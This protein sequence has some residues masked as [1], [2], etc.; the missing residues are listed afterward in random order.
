MGILFIKKT[1]KYTSEEDIATKSEKLGARGP[2][3]LSAHTRL[4]PCWLSTFFIVFTRCNAAGGS[5]R[6][7]EG[8]SVG[9]NQH[10]LGARGGL[11][12]SVAAACPLVCLFLH[13]S[14]SHL[15]SGFGM[16]PNL[17]YHFSFSSL[18]N[19]E[20]ND[21]IIER[22]DCC[23]FLDGS[24]ERKLQLLKVTWSRNF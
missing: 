2:T 4:I 19:M 1:K 14:T 8:G 7:G 13:Y 17:I 10:Q 20:I 9:L 23:R 3:V 18:S 12:G 6:R 15:P 24:E 22:Q 5:S 11:R 21:Y 16:V